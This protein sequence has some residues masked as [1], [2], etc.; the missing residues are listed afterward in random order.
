MTDDQINRMIAAR[1]K[2]TNVR[3]ERIDWT[4]VDAI[5]TMLRDVPA[6]QRNDVDLLLGRSCAVLPTR[7]AIRIAADEVSVTAEWLSAAQVAQLE[8]IERGRRDWNS[9][10]GDLDI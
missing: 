9:I 1:N 6:G 4:T 7:E 10:K 5:D 2:L 3:D 8:E